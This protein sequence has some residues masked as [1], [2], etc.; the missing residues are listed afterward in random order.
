METEQPKIAK[1][2]GIRM[3]SVI[4]GQCNWVKCPDVECYCSV[5]VQIS[6]IFGTTTNNW[7]S[8]SGHFARRS[9]T[10]NSY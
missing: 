10:K 3:V 4:S 9:N 2:C 6:A 7:M 1:R 5:T 8:M